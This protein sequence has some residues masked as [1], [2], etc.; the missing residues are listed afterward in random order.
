MRE[1]ETP[2]DMSTICRAACCGQYR[3]AASSVLAFLPC[4]LHPFHFEWQKGRGGGSSDASSE[5]K[6]KSTQRREF[7]RFYVVA[8]VQLPI[9]CLLE[10]S[11]ITLETS[12]RESKG[13]GGAQRG[14]K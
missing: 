1:A 14:R 9:E 4:N 7:N 8:P 5:G 6:G 2:L 10:R 3:L 12:W 13:G 11:T